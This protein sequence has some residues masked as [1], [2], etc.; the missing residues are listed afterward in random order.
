M[1]KNV[2]LCLEFVSFLILKHRKP[3]LLR[4]YTV[5]GQRI[6]GSAGNVHFNVLGMFVSNG[7]QVASLG[8]GCRPFPRLPLCFMR[9]TASVGKVLPT[10]FPRFSDSNA[11]LFQCG[12]VFAVEMLV[13]ICVQAGLLAAGWVWMRYIP[14]SA[15]RF[16]G[17]P[18]TDSRHPML[19]STSRGLSE[20]S[21]PSL[22]DYF[23]VPHDAPAYTGVPVYRR[24]NPDE[25]GIEFEA[26]HVKAQLF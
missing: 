22:P 18:E 4:P 21:L 2:S 9:T 1:F 23:E 20:K 17:D 25:D 14:D 15:I 10:I 24:H 11:C 3:E 13:W 5:P 7:S 16:Y 6:H 19:P 8:P 12:C 26:P